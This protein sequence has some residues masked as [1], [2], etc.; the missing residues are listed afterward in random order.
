MYDKWW[1]IMSRKWPNTGPPGLD[2]NARIRQNPFPGMDDP[3]WAVASTYPAKTPHTPLAGKKGLSMENMMKALREM[4]QPA[5][6]NPA[7]AGTFGERRP[8]LPGPAPF[9]PVAGVNQS[10][11]N[12]MGLPDARNKKWWEIMGY[13]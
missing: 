13:S 2:P 3:N 6:M 7:P 10:I 12:T 9:T 4:K 1:G 5:P 11:M 8:Q